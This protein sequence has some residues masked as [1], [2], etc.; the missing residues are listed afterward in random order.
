MKLAE[1][2]RTDE[3]NKK[4]W[5]CISE[6]QRQVPEMAPYSAADIKLRFMHALGMEM[7]FLPAIEGQGMFPVGMRS[8]QLTVEQF[9]ALL[10]LLHAYAA[11]NGVDFDDREAA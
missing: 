3:Q 2:T 11:R 10:E 8:S 1:P 6:I 7:R 4:L 5:A 9:S